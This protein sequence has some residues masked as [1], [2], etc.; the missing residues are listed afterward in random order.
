MTMVAESRR[1]LE[2]LVDAYPGYVR[3][4][5]PAV[6]EGIDDAIADGQ[7]WL[8]AALTDLFLRPFAAQP[9]GPLEVFQEA[10]KFPTAV[11]EQAGVEA[12]SRDPV[13]EAA[14]PGDLYDLAP[15]STRDLGE[16]VWTIHLMWGATKA[17]ALT[18]SPTTQEPPPD[19]P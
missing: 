13:A 14:L 15:A 16:E 8:R 10:M 11:L 17:G 7:T 2:A 12:P 9:R 5:L 6:P 1:L 18:G 3:S 4:R 19:T